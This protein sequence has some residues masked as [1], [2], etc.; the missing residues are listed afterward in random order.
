MFAALRSSALALVVLFLWMSTSQTTHATCGDHL[1]AQDFSLYPKFN[2]ASDNDDPEGITWDGTYWR[3]V[4]REDRRVYTH[5]AGGVRVSAVE[6]SLTGANAD[7]HGMTWD[8]THCFVEDQDDSLCVRLLFCR[9]LH[10]VRDLFA[11]G[12]QPSTQ[13]HPSSD[14]CSGRTTTTLAGQRCINDS[15]TERKLMYDIVLWVC[16]DSGPAVARPGSAQP[17]RHCRC[18]R[19]QELF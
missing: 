10:L 7:A 11:D 2:L 17:P 15:V 3:V 8:G 5:D 12:R 9:R 6:L 16:P 19:L 18:I 1:S 4:D 14:N 13:W